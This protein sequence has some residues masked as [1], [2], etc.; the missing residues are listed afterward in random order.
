[1]CFR[2]ITDEKEP[3]RK[4]ERKQVERKEIIHFKMERI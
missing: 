3:G 4:K 1:V 2:W